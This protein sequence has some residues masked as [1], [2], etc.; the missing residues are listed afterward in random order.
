[1]YIKKKKQKT[2]VKDCEGKTI[3]TICVSFGFPEWYV[4]LARYSFSRL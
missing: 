1:M 4:I 3:Y 2:N